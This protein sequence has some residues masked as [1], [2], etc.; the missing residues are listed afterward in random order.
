MSEGPTQQ[1]TGASPQPFMPPPGGSSLRGG[2]MG[3]GR[4]FAQQH[5]QLHAGMDGQMGQI[6][7]PPIQMQPQ[8]AVMPQAQPYGMLGDAT[9]TAAPLAGQIPKV[10]GGIK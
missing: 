9:G 2:L 7:T 8:P 6:G 4:G 10:T 5:D 3:G 1:I